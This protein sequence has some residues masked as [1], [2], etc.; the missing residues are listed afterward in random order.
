[1]KILAN[2]SVKG[3]GS[4]IPLPSQLRK[5]LQIN[6]KRFGCPP[7]ETEGFSGFLM[8]MERK[9]KARHQARLVSFDPILR[10]CELK[11]CG[12]LGQVGSTKKGIH[13]A[14]RKSQNCNKAIHIYS[15]WL[16][17][18]KPKLRSVFHEQIRV[19]INK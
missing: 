14:V 2:L 13:L 5:G 7:R 11:I 4:E 10:G 9:G 3:T 15:Q 12:D 6:F 17:L 18:L 16:L 1:M 19:Q 8:N